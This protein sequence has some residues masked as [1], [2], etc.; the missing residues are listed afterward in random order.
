MPW[1]QGLPL[2]TLCTIPT[3]P[4]CGIIVAQRV[5]PSARKPRPPRAQAGQAV[6]VSLPNGARYC[7]Q[8]ANLLAV[9]PDFVSKVR[10]ALSSDDS[11]SKTVQVKDGL[12]NAATIHPNFFHRSPAFQLDHERNQGIPAVHPLV[13]SFDR[14]VQAVRF[15]LLAH[16]LLSASRLPC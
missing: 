1:F 9:S 13:E 14:L 16:R 11:F 2:L 10:P 5:G 6:G 3:W 7:G 4:S 8:I 15:D 12:I